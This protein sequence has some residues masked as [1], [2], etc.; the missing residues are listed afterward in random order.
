MLMRILIYGAGVIGSFYA[1]LFAEAGY[2]TSIYARGKRL[3]VLRTNGL[4]YKKNQEVIKAE[5]KILGELPN[6]D[7]Y[8]FVLLTVRENQL[9][10]EL[11]EV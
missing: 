4:L 11:V 7:I 2:D 10:Q 6:D 1:A 5:I 9:F 8:D 3:E